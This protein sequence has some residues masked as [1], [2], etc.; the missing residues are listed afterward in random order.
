MPIHDWTRVKAGTFHHFHTTWIAHLA[1]ALNSGVLPRDYYALAEQS[2]G[3]V[4]P[5]VLTLQATE[6]DEPPPDEDPSREGTV[7]VAEAPPR[8]RFTAEVE[9][10]AYARKRR[11]LVIR[12]SGGDR[13]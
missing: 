6:T 5:D 2:T 4:G 13:V 11:R 3:Q 1:E 7:A 8:V 9:A 12:Y 10:G